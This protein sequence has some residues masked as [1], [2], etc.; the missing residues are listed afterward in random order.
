MKELS[1]REMAEKSE[2]HPSTRGQLKEYAQTS[3]RHKVTVCTIILSQRRVI[4]VFLNG[5]I[6]WHLG[7]FQYIS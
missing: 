1:T 4:I 7:I 5:K 2:H 6:P 3:G